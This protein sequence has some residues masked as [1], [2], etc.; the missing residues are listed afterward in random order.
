M[1]SKPLPCNDLND[2]AKSK[3]AYLKFPTIDDLSYRKLTILTL[4]KSNFTLSS[5]HSQID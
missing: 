4:Y 1:L 3:R 2:L 5:L